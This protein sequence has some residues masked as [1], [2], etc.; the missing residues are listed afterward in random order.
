MAWNE[1]KENEFVSKLGNNLI[2]GNINGLGKINTGILNV[3]DGKFVLPIIEGASRYTFSFN[4]W[5][6][7]YK[8]E[9][10][11]NWGSESIVFK[12]NSSEIS[13]ANILAQKFIQY[14]YSENSSQ[15]VVE[16]DDF[17]TKYYTCGNNYVYIIDLKSYGDCDYATIAL[18]PKVSF[19][20]Y[21]DA[22][23]PLAV[24]AYDLNKLA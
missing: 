6:S 22:G 18:Q 12:I 8:D 10:L 15:K 3:N 4:I 5:N 7:A 13:N 19:V 9:Q 23:I 14:D 20:A 11:I 16:H 24:Y 17:G 1:E 21:N 2:N